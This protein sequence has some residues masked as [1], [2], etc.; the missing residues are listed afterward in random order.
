MTVRTFHSLGLSIIG[1]AEGKR[2]TLAPSAE[3]DRALFELLKGERVKSYEECEIA[4]YLYLN[5]IAYEYEAPYEHDTA[6][7]DKRQYLPD[8][9][10]PEHGNYIESSNNRAGS[11]RSRDCSRRS[12]STSRAPGCP[13]PKSPNARHPS[14]TASGRKR[15]WPCSGRYSSAT[16]NR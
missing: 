13:S 16:R 14:L 6:T 8:F 4:N 9:H 15:S 2:P 1:Q 10:L 11:T 3:S 5:G 12:C 7:P